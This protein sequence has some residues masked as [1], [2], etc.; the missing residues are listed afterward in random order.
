MCHAR[1]SHHKPSQAQRRHWQAS[2]ST[3]AKHTSKTRY[4]SVPPTQPPYL[5]TRVL[6]LWCEYLQSHHTPSVNSGRSVTFRETCVQSQEEQSTNYRDPLRW[7]ARLIDTLIRLIASLYFRSR[8]PKLGLFCIFMTS[9]K[10]KEVI[11]K[12]R[13]GGWLLIMHTTRGFLQQ[14]CRILL[15]V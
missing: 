15:C 10:H 1:F 11:F 14:P 13:I 12:I 8:K 2:G 5:S 3:V 7:V 9:P 4:R 6:R